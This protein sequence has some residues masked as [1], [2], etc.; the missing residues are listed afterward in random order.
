MSNWFMVTLVGKDR[1]GIVAHVCSALYE[2]GANLGETSMLRLG[3][4]FTIMMMVNYDGTKKALSEILSTEAESLDLQLHVDA[5]D[6][7]LHRHLLPSMR[8]TVAGA[9][10]AGIVARV[11]GV[12]AEVGFNILELESDVAGSEEKPIYILHIEGDSPEGMQAVAS[13]LELVRGDGIDVSLSPV[14]TLIG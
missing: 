10:R 4:N 3:G 14:D 6:G 2:G 8:I 1:P 12:L 9:D 7:Q 13:A 5:I 11:T